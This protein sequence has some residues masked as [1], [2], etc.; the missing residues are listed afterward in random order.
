[1]KTLETIFSRSFLLI[2]GSSPIIH[3][4]LQEFTYSSTFHH[5]AFLHQTMPNNLAH[6]LIRNVGLISDEFL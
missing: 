3:H 6:D 5:G 4:D 1:M 2:D